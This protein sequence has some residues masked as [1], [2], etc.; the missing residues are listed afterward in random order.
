M[1]AIWERAIL[2]EGTWELQAMLTLL[3]SPKI[4]TLLWLDQEDTLYVSTLLP[5]T[6]PAW[7]IYP[8]IFASGPTAFELS[9]VKLLEHHLISFKHPFDN[10]SVIFPVQF[11]SCKNIFICP[12]TLSLFDKISA[13]KYMITRSHYLWFF[14]EFPPGI[15]ILSTWSYRKPQQFCVHNYRNMSILHFDTGF[16][17]KSCV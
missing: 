9:M 2:S 17:P 15:Y 14:P 6:A 13:F 12:S 10:K 1:Q 8:V 11:L 4:K 5:F 3:G 16:I 7:E